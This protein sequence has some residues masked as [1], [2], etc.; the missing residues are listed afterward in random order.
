MLFVLRCSI[1]HSRT[2]TVPSLLY[3]IFIPGTFPEITHF[4]NNKLSSNY[5]QYNKTAN[6]T[7]WGK[8]NKAKHKTN[9]QH[10]KT[11]QKQPQKPIHIYV[12]A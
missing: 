5:Q 12:T 2:Q 10:N 9:K 11:K 4:E 6:I 7:K 3:H 8:T 1:Q